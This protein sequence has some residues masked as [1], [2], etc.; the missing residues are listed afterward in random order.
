MSSETGLM[1]EGEAARFLDLSVRTLQKWR[2]N[3][4][5]PKFLRLNGAVRYDRADLETFI[6]SGRRTSTSDA[7]VRLA[8]REAA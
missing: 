4:R 5:G 6:S 2:W 7:G 8:G 3:G 1:R